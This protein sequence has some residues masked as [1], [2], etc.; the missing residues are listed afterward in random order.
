MMPIGALVTV[1]GKSGSEEK[2][3]ELL[4]AAIA[5][6]RTEPGNMMAVVLRDL[7]AAN[8]FHVFEFYKDEAAVQAHRVAPHTIKRG[9]LL[10]ALF[11]E[12]F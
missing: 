1:S 10:Q 9:L 11:T 7:D 6:V 8:K 12:P 5:D 4:N 3:L 2:L